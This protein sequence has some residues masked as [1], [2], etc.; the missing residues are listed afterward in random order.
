VTKDLQSGFP[1]A[2]ALHQA[3]Q[4]EAAKTEYRRVLDADPR[5]VGALL[6]L[7]NLLTSENG[8]DEALTYCERA[9]AIAPDDPQEL[10]CAGLIYVKQG[11]TEQAHKFLIEA[12]SRIT[13]DVLNSPI[14]NPWKASYLARI[15]GLSDPAQ[16]CRG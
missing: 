7:A 5:H 11:D 16:P 13:S 3:G 1:A 10:R 8:L 6:N 15:V 2:L 12:V 9:I 14:G 4:A